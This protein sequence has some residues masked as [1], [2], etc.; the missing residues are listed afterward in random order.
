M[1]IRRSL[2]ATVAV[3]ALVVL[4]LSAIA[5]VSASDGR[6]LIQ[7]PERHFLALDQMN[8]LGLAVSR[9]IHEIND[10]ANGSADREQLV[11][12]MAAARAAVEAVEPVEEG[13][14][15]DGHRS[16]A[17]FTAIVDRIDRD[18]GH[19]VA[20]LGSND[21]VAAL[22]MSS[23]LGDK[24]FERDFLK[25][26]ATATADAHAALAANVVE[27]E[28]SADRTRTYALGL[29]ALGVLVMLGAA[30]SVRRIQ[31][32]LTGLTVVVSRMAGGALDT[33]TTDVG[34][35]DELGDL[36]RTFNAMAGNL[37]RTVA[38]VA[39][40][41][42]LAQELA[43]AARMQQS[44]LP[45]TVAMPGLEI[46]AVMLASDQIGGDYYDLHVTDDGGWIGIGDVSG[47][48][49][50]AGVVMIMAQS[51]IAS[52]I[53]ARPDAGP[54]EILGLANHVLYENVRTRLGLREHMTLSLLR[55]RRDGRVVY[56]GAHQ[57]MLVRGRDGAVREVATVGPWLALVPE[58]GRHLVERE[59]V[60]AAGE[61]LVLFTDG[62]TEARRLDGHELG[63]E[64]LAA[65]VAGA[66]DAEVARLCTD[67]MAGVQ[68]G[69]RGF[70]DD[71]TIVVIRRTD[72]TAV[73]AAA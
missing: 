72:D 23:D 31:R 50:N 56:A 4:A 49:F 39:E 16:D 54:A 2:T 17:P 71:A 68:G 47:H 62:I 65:V 9:V 15:H 3:T 45:R 52:C 58:V 42:A 70:E 57:E 59:L 66:D 27:G 64:G 35:V 61:A 55:Y 67:I 33:R 53:R 22:S 46:A 21:T 63:L 73:A 18:R 14:D 40:K 34:V 24:V 37:E 6:R 12:A 7:A 11:A 25:L 69:V 8:Q 28:R 26:L 43:L 30:V 44:I 36:G 48:G 38:A 20:L 1:T 5:L 41:E 32:R 51:T 10:A 60:L 13:A 19:I 29:A